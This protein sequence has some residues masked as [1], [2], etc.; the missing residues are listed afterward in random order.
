MPSEIEEII[1]ELLQ[2]MRNPSSDIRWSAAKGIGRITSRLPKEFGD[3]VVGSVVEILNPLEP[4]EAW[5]GACLAIAE[6]GMHCDF[7]IPIIPHNLIYSK[8]PITNSKTWSIA[9]IS[10]GNNGTFTI[11]SS[12]LR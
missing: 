2:A 9:A 1:E 10:S 4:H 11:A 7:T 6:L 8:F 3:E 5:H 12:R